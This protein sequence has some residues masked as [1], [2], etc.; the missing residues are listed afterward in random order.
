MPDISD[1]NAADC[2]KIDTLVRENR[3]GRFD[4]DRALSL[5]NRIEIHDEA[6]GIAGATFREAV[7]LG[8]QPE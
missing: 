5:V 7:G 2:S 1:T 3:R 8:G 6:G 4:A